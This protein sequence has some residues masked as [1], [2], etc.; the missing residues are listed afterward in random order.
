MEVKWIGF[1]SN[2][3]VLRLTGLDE[4]D[5]ADAEDDGGRLGG[6]AN[7]RVGSAKRDD[8]PAGV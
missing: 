3:R 4:R 5:I 6:L 8:G 2:P 7:G 1:D